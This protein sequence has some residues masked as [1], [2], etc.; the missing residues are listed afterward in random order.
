MVGNHSEVGGVRLRDGV[1]GRRVHPRKQ[2]TSESGRETALRGFDITL[3]P[4]KGGLVLVRRTWIRS[5][6]R[7]RVPLAEGISPR[8]KSLA[9]AGTDGCNKLWVGMIAE[10]KFKLVDIDGSNNLK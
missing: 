5:V 9:Q 10:K 3:R 6:M 1:D 7:N 4:Q 8:P 2:L